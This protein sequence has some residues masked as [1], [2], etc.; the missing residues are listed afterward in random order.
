MSGIRRGGTRKRA[1]ST[2]PSADTT[3]SIR[4]GSTPCTH[5]NRRRKQL[6]A[7]QRRRHDGRVCRRVDPIQIDGFGRA[8]LHEQW[9]AGC[10]RRRVCR[11]GRAAAGVGALLQRGCYGLRSDD[12]E[13]R[14]A[15]RRD[16]AAGGVSRFAWCSGIGL[17][18]P[19]CRPR[20]S[21]AGL[22][23]A[24]SGPL[25]RHRG[26]GLHV[27][28]RLRLGRRPREHRPGEVRAA[29][30]QHDHDDG[31]PGEHRLAPQSPF[32]PQACQPSRLCRWRLASPSDGKGIAASCRENRSKTAT[33]RSRPPG[34][35]K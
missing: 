18:E 7:S 20:P 6:L 11:L 27:R 23:A 22:G 2:V 14:V 19:A 30:H 26:L 4:S 24:S 10:R 25:R 1:R 5:A 12:L 16:G 33:I 34:F 9:R 31:A 21:R 32:R 28:N 15:P 3:S 29:K 17:P 13:I 8:V 35:A